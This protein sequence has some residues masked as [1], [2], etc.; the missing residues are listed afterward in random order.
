MS[1]LLTGTFGK[2]PRISISIL[3][4]GNLCDKAIDRL[5]YIPFTSDIP[6]LVEFVKKP[7]NIHGGM[8]E[9]SYEQVMQACAGM[10]WDPEAL[11]ILCI[12]GDQVPC[13][14]EQYA[15]EKLPYIDWRV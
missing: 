8:A 6:A 10:D 3:V 2:Y 9:A 7:R 1:E 14:K 4:H 13:T 5:Q 12:I 11:K 15:H